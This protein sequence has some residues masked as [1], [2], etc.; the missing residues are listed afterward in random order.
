MHTA[1]TLAWRNA[2][3]RALRPP[4]G[5]RPSRSRDL[6]VDCEQLETDEQEQNGAKG[7]EDE[8]PV[9]WPRRERVTQDARKVRR[10]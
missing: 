2:D 1:Q 9:L 6:V 10:F 3:H 7:G 8:R 4:A 5:S